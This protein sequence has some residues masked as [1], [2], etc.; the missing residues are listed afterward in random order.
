MRLLK[1][2][3]TIFG[4]YNRRNAYVWLNESIFIKRMITGVNLKCR[5]IKK[6]FLLLFK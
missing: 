4:A 6:S 3:I 5:I 1:K 2:I